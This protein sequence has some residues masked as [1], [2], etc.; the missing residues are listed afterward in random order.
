MNLRRHKPGGRIDWAAAR[1]KLERL[2]RNARSTGLSPERVR[3]ILDERARTLSQRPAREPSPEDSSLE[4]VTF[5]LASERYAIETRYVREVVRLVDFTPVPG[6]PEFVVG[7]TNHRGQILCIVDLR[8][9]LGV[10]SIGLTDLSRVI[11]VGGD[12]AEFGVLADRTDAIDSLLRSDLQSPSEAA[13]GVGCEYLL[14]V[15]RQA[16]LVLN[17]ARLLQDPRLFIDQRE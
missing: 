9:F 14:G 11:V 2:Q 13:I 1:R 12:T 4:V 6:A 3:A 16:V 8:S 17:G 10:P 15:T 7:V 5:A